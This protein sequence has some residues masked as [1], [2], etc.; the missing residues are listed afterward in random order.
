MWSHRSCCRLAHSAS[1]PVRRR[2]L[3]GWF[4]LVCR[5]DHVAMVHRS[6]WWSVWSR[7][8]FS[9]CCWRGWAAIRRRRHGPSRSCS[10]STV[11]LRST[12]KNWYLS[13]FLRVKLYFFV[14]F[15]FTI[16]CCCWPLPLLLP[17]CAG[18]LC[19]IG[20]ALET[21]FMQVGFKWE[22]MIMRAVY[23]VRTADWP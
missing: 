17:P 3:C 23:T 7:H 22:L 6:R 20:A 2:W 15:Y 12:R 4:G 16:C 10:R 18:D 11:T 9:R 14:S 19:C 1:R 8:L 5:H 21:K 13:Q